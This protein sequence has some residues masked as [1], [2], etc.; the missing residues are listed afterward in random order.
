M[1]LTSFQVRVELAFLAESTAAWNSP[2]WTR[3]DANRAKLEILL[4]NN[5]AASYIFSL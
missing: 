1:H 4:N 5:L 3:V 2:R